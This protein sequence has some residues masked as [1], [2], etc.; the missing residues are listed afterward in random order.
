MEE[1]KD[2]GLPLKHNPYKVHMCVHGQLT[3]PNKL[4]EGTPSPFQLA[5][6]Y[7]L[8]EIVYCTHTSAHVGKGYYAVK[9]PWQQVAVVLVC[10]N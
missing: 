8:K 9:Q 6:S 2:I 5:P 4:G 7:L 10:K 3:F 1:M